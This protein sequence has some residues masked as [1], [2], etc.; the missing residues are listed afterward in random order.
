M[1]ILNFENTRERA[2][3]LSL[4]KNLIEKNSLVPVIGAG[5]SLDTPTD[6]GGQVPSGA[7]LHSTLYEFVE[8]H[9]GYSKE[10]LEEIKRYRLSDIADVFWNIYDRIPE[11][12]LHSY[13]SYIETNFLGISFFK[14][15][16]EAFLRIRWPYLFT[17]NY[18]S[19]IEDFNFKKDYYPVIPFDTINQRSP[20]SKTRVYKLHGDAKKYRDTG[21]RKYFILS[22]EQYVK[23][24]M[25]LSNEDMLSELK[26]AFSSK[27]I[28]FF[29]CSLSEE[30]DLL[31][32]SQLAIEEKIKS[33][34]LAHQAAIY[35]SFEYGRNGATPFPLRMEDQLSKYGI[36]HV[37]RIFTEDQ[38]ES[39]FNE[40]AEYSCRIPRPGID[41]FLEKHSAINYRFLQPEDIGSREFFFQENLIWKDFSN[42]TITIPGYC[43]KRS[44]MKKIIE[45]ISSGE[46]MF[47]I[48]GNYFSGKTFLLVAI[49][50]YFSTK[51]VYIF[52]SGTHLTA[53]QLDA[54]LSK[55]DSIF[56]FDSKT[57]STFQIKDLSQNSQLE[58]IRENHSSAIIVIDASDAPMYKYIF[59]ARNTARE[60]PQVR[61]SSVLNDDE[62]MEFN[63]KIGQ[64]SFP[65]YSKDETLLDYI[66]EN[67]KELLVSPES[68]SHFLDPNKQLLA[69]NPLERIKA[70]IMLATEIRIPAKRAI[71][72][73]IDG[74]INDMIKCCRETSGASIIEKDYFIYKGDS[75]GYEF[76]CNSKYWIIRALSAYANTRSDS[77]STVANAY[78][79]IIT[80]YKGIY[81]DDNVR[82]YQQCEP[83]YFFDHIQ[84]LFNQR[85]FSNPSK[86]IN[87]IYDRLLPALSDSYQF[88]HQKA[89]GKLIIGQVQL[90]K[91]N[92]VDGKETLKDAL[93]N[94]TRAIKL[95]QQFPNAKNIMETLLH[96]M[97]TKG[98]ILIE[99]SCTSR[100]YI[101]QAVETCYQLYRMQEDVKH[102]AYDF[103]SGTGSDKVSF[104]KFKFT[105]IENKTVH[106]FEDLDLEKT[107]FLLTR[108]TGKKFRITKKRRPK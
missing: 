38:S 3:A 69:I 87:A 51:K 84:L 106:A 45:S 72:F 102:D 46:P 78:L 1:T 96:M 11:E 82:F 18:D 49:S 56:C 65:P 19:L 37:L 16:Q 9:S 58:K 68:T 32:S 48:S 31:Y 4:C 61:I 77:I 105:L 22:R 60:F 30:L 23:S 27:S 13:F 34:D 88:L 107:E 99:F 74:H 98:R 104:E 33:I 67:E 95:A 53:A 44:E 92:F 40:L 76:V 83:Y 50:K 6:N 81:K 7:K 97:Y 80:H 90:K 35:I 100:K 89:K 26:T 59:E 86:L 101:P 39:F 25:D 103:T 73:G 47:F 57:L 10:E 62:E 12:D 91:R 41:T 55:K 108:W 71:Q 36:T 29:G 43:V 8:K 94:I 14:D 42:H 17:L 93:L 70:L 79:S 66:V 64:I 21:D 28:L 24:M 2:I 54:L 15:F 5:F 85:W 63:Q 75:S 52:P 20:V